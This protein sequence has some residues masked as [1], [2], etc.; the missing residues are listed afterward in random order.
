MQT[1]NGFVLYRGPSMLD[2]APIVAIVT[3]TASRSDNPKTGAMLQTWIMREDIAPTLALK[4]GADASVCGDCKHRPANGGACYV[5]VHQGPLSV[6]KAHG[7]GNYPL[8]DDV[9]ALG[10]GRAVRLGSY[11]DPA[12]VPVSVWEAFVSRATSHTGYTHQ[13]RN[14]SS[15]LRA[16]CMASADDATERDEA[17]AMGWRTF[18]V[19]CADEPL[20]ERESV[21]PASAEAGFKTNCATCGACSGADG[22]RGSI[23]IVVHGSKARKFIALR[24]AA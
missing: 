18:R 7:R 8:A 19:R 21:C 2:G 15:A 14:A 22:K 11:G 4:S 1:P 6:W 23:A 3:G 13:W 12:A 9:A 10:A 24:I 16:L 20:G 17:R 5:V